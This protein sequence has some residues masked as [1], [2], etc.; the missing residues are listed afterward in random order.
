[1]EKKRGGNTYTKSSF[2]A[3]HVFLVFQM[4]FFVKLHL[5]DAKGEVPYSGFIQ[6]SL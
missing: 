5:E 6:V 4:M 3:V 1:M 2:S